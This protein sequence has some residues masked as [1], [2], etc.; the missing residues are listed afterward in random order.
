GQGRVRPRANRRTA[1]ERGRNR[2]VRAQRDRVDP[3]PNP[4]RIA[5]QPSCFTRAKTARL[6]A[7]ASIRSSDY[8]GGTSTGCRETAARDGLMVTK[9]TATERGSPAAVRS[10]WELVRGASHH[11][12]CRLP[13]NEQGF[14]PVRPLPRTA[15]IRVTREGRVHD[16]DSAPRDNHCDAG[17]IR[18]AESWSC[19]LP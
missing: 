6:R 9:N 1:L 13:G 12:A 17:T 18:G 7:L 14:P 8:A 2:G 15:R 10:A 19:T 16:H 11:R 5:L 4:A 3:R